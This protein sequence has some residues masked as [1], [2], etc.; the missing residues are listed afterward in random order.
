MMVMMLLIQSL[1]EKQFIVLN[2]LLGNK[3]WMMK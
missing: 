1:I 3:P 2:S